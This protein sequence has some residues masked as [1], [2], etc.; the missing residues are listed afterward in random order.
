LLATLNAVHKH[1][2]SVD[3]TKPERKSQK[4]QTQTER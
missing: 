4:N 2:L 3:E 1:S